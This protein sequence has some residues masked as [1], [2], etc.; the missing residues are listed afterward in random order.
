M[1]RAAWFRRRRGRINIW[2]LVLRPPESYRGAL[3]RVLKVIGTDISDHKPLSDAW[4]DALETTLD[5]RSLDSITRDEMLGHGAY[6]GKGLYDRTRDQFWKLVRSRDA[7]TILE[8]AGLMFGDEPAPN[9]EVTATDVPP[10]ELKVSLD[11]KDEKAQGEN[12]R[13][14]VDPANLKF[15]FLAPNSFR[16]AVQVRLKLRVP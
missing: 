15:E 14:A 13:R 6:E 1:R 11:H 3:L 2:D 5:G 12:W 10:N 7:R 16:E 8:D 4:S 9:L